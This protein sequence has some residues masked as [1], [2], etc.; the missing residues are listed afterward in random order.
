MPKI[1]KLTDM[2]RE[3]ARS[4][5]ELAKRKARYRDDDEGWVFRAKAI[6]D[7]CGIA[8]QAVYQWDV[9]PEG[10]VDAVSE[11]SEVPKADLRPDLYDKGADGG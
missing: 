2:Q 3:R 9:V 8:R 1:K 11:V 7:R 6:A 4:A 5:L 10:R